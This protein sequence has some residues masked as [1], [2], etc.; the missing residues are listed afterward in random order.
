MDSPNISVYD[1]V[2]PIGGGPATMI[3]YFHKY[4]GVAWG[5]YPGQQVLKPCLPDDPEMCVIE[6][7]GANRDLYRPWDLE[8]I[9]RSPA[10]TS[11]NRK[12]YEEFLVDN[13]L[14]GLSDQ[15]TDDFPPLS[16]HERLKVIEWQR[17]TKI[18]IQEYLDQPDARPRRIKSA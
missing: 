10:S 15:D 16:N 4:A 9:S 2:Q 5:R 18:R 17:E 11:A 3:A 7:E 6:L 13:G 12:R 8:W 1:Y 14:L